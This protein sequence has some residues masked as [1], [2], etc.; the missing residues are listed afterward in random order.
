MKWIT[1]PFDFEEVKAVKKTNDQS[2]KEATK[3]REIISGGKG[4]EE[5]SLEGIMRRRA[6]H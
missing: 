6:I 1:L 3:W 4:G 5:E 2:G